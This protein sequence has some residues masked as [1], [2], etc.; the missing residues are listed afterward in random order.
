MA[1]PGRRPRTSSPTRSGLAGG[2]VS[3][4]TPAC[5]LWQTASRPG[6][7]TTRTS[8]SG[9][10]GCLVSPIRR[11]TASGFK[12][13]GEGGVAGGINEMIQRRRAPFGTLL[14]HEHHHLADIGRPD[15]AV[16]VLSGGKVGRP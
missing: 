10:G 7:L 16:G 12:L 1:G 15:L 4:L 11:W 2:L 13:T 14:L 6:T 9:R 3:T 5:C 8:A